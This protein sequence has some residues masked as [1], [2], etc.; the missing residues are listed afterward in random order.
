MPPRRPQST[1]I[2]DEV[3]AT[4]VPW[5]HSAL[6]QRAWLLK[7]VKALKANPQHKSYAYGNYC[8]ARGK[9]AVYSAEH[10]TAIQDGTVLGMAHTMENPM[11]AN[12]YRPTPN[13]LS[14]AQALRFV[15]APE[16]LAD[17]REQFLSDI[18]EHMEDDGAA[19]EYRIAANDDPSNLL[20]LLHDECDNISCTISNE[21]ESKFARLINKGLTS[22]DVPSF[23]TLK[24][25]CETLNKT[26]RRE[27]RINDALMAGKLLKAVNKLGPDIRRDL[28]AE[29]RHRAADGNLPLTC[30]AIRHVLGEAEAEDAGDNVL[31]NA[32]AGTGRDTRNNRLPGQDPRKSAVTD[33]RPPG[34]THADRPWQSSDGNCRHCGKSGHWNRD[35]ASAP[36]PK[37]AKKARA[38]AAKAAKPAAADPAETDDKPA[39]QARFSAATSAASPHHVRVGP[40]AAQPASSGATTINSAESFIAGLLNT[41]TVLA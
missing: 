30:A 19:N 36:A 41:T 29:M 23:N 9:T 18:I 37:S 25:A 24:T 26:V 34:L 1:N 5:D 15:I 31:G 4:E 17:E 7:R 8:T 12:T 32:L 11:P 13:A 33:G 27:E 2:T 35:C 38:K 20:G 22:A 28:K 3:T 10:A 39:G 40:P 6:T 16:I 21:A 14:A